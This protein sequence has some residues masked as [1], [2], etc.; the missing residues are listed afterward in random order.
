MNRKLALVAAVAAAVAAGWAGQRLHS[1]YAPRTAGRGVAVPAGEASAPTAADVRASAADLAANAR[2]GLGSAIKIP[3]RLPQ[4]TLNGLDGKPAS[5]E[6]LHGRSLIINFW[7]TWCAPCR[8]EIPLL[9][10]VDAT[11]RA[12][13]FSVVGIAVDH[14]ADVARF[15][16]RLKIAYPLMSGEQDALDVAAA[17]GV[18]DPAFPF[19]VFTDDRGRVVALYLGELREPQIRL[20]LA[21]V[22]DL[23][24]D[25]ILLPAAQ[26]KIKHGLQAIAANNA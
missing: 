2:E 3:E 16:A 1:A 5:L 25:K 7:A 20:I 24:A 23:N 4:F 8:Q 17:F 26:L 18:V 21:V 19:T 22:Q 10:E 11:W 6:P 12:R 13:N 9:Q 14:R 15:A